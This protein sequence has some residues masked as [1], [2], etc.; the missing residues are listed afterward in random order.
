MLIIETSAARSAA[1]KFAPARKVHVVVVIA[2]CI[3]IG[4]NIDSRLLT[5]AFSAA[6]T[7]SSL[8]SKNTCNSP[9]TYI[10]LHRYMFP[11]WS[12][13]VFRLRCKALRSPNGTS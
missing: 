10:A 7:S 13:S 3:S 1:A 2:L 8:F 9:K 11:P 6:M 12:V 5:V 4:F